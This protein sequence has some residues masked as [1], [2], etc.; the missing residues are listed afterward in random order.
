[1]LSPRPRPVMMSMKDFHRLYLTSLENINC[2]VMS[3]VHSKEIHMDSHSRRKVSGMPFS[4]FFRCYGHS[5]SLMHRVSAA[6][7]YVK[8]QHSLQD[9]TQ[10]FLASVGTETVSGKT[11]DKG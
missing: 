7:R 10:I 1:M 6:V 8:L 4:T 3:G 2:A 5:Q 11:H 9:T